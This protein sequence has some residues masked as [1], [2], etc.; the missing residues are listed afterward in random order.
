MHSIKLSAA[1]QIF[2]EQLIPI[3]QHLMVLK[4]QTESYY[5]RHLPKKKY[6]HGD[7]FDTLNRVALYV[8]N[9]G[10]KP[11]KTFAPS[12][13]IIALNGFCNELE[14]ILKTDY[15]I[16]VTYLGSHVS[17]KTLTKDLTVSQ[18]NTFKTKFIEFLKNYETTL[19]IINRCIEFKPQNR[20]DWLKARLGECVVQPHLRKLIPDKSISAWRR[21]AED[22]PLY[23]LA[24]VF[25]SKTLPKIS[26][27]AKS[28]RARP[29]VDLFNTTFGTNIVSFSEF[30]QFPAFQIEKSEESVVSVI[31]TKNKAQELGEAIFKSL[32][33]NVSVKVVESKSAPYFEIRAEGP[34]FNVKV[35]KRDIE[36]VCK[37]SVLFGFAIPI[38]VHGLYTKCKNKSSTCFLKTVSFADLQKTIKLS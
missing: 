11:S 24:K 22:A 20:N 3:A 19:N 23:A 17:D 13:L 30:Q 4:D 38:D 10:S 26:K 7:C 35:L 5:F 25:E 27:F 16:K 6:Y 33:K 36:K 8:I 2:A 9:S 28:Y 32:P 29:S 14:T 12:N 1:A 18:K 34:V 21:F 15:G 37:N 31:G